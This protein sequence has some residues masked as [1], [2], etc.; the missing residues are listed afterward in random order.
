MSSPTEE[1]AHFEDDDSSSSDH[2]YTDADGALLPG[3]YRAMYAFSPEGDTEMALE[4]GQVVHVV[5][6]GGG[7]GWAVV[8]REGADAQ[9]NRHALV[10]E[11]YLELVKLDESDGDE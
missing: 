4:D 5:G 6:R 8:I 9:G 11:S 3:F 7:Q 1:Q 10:P 2:E